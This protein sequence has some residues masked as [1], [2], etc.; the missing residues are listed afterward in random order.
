MKRFV[1]MENGQAVREDVTPDALPSDPT[2]PPPV[3][4]EQAERTAESVRAA[5]ERVRAGAPVTC[6]WCGAPVTEADT[7]HGPGECSRPLVRF[8]G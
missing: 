2:L 1:R 7:G 5:I 3:T 4:A 8:G 6:G